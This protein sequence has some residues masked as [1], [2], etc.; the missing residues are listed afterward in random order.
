MVEIAQ[1]Y[2]EEPS[3]AGR[4]QRNGKAATSHTWLIAGH[5]R[6]E[7]LGNDCATPSAS[8]IYSASS[9]RTKIPAGGKMLHDIRNGSSLLEYQIFCNRNYVAV[10][11]CNIVYAQSRDFDGSSM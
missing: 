3:V 11:I 5:M 7:P 2:A 10:E 1:P 9:N 8:H 6:D 4:H